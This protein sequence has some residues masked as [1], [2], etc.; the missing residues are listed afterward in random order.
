MFGDQKG[1]DV[2]LWDDNLRVRLDL[3]NLTHSRVQG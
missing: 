2:E 1:D 3:D